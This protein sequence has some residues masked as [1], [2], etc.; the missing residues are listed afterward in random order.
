MERNFKGI[1]IPKEIWLNENLTLEEKGFLAEIYSIDDG[2]GCR[3]SDE[4]FSKFFQ[5]PE[6]K[7]SEIINSLENKGLIEIWDICKEAPECGG[8]RVIITNFK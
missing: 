3:V 5:M 1:W 8:K 2:N 4:Y 7:C 6:N